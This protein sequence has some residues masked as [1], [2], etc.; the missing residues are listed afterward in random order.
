MT[1]NPCFHCPDRTSECHADC[2]SY[3]EYARD[4]REYLKLRWKTKKTKR[5]LA[6]IKAGCIRSCTHGKIKRAE[7]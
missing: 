4:R 1:K 6:D 3:G 5:D 7:V 2:T